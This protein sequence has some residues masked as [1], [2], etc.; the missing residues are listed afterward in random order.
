MI[1]EPDAR[2]ELHERYADL[3]AA[4]FVTSSPTPMKAAL[5]MLGIEVGGL[6]LPMVEASDEEAAHVRAAL[7]RHGLL[8][9]V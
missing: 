3:F 5:N 7:E 6:R 9:A 1:D 4:M 2:H 8:S